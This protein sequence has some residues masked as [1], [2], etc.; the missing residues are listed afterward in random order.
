M[1]RHEIAVSTAGALPS[2]ADV[3]MAVR[4]IP[5]RGIAY[6]N[7]V[8]WDEKGD[9]VAAVTALHVVE[10]GRFHQV[11]EIARGELTTANIRSEPQ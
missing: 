7:A 3:I 6:S 10:D 9:N 2:R 8:Q 5:F 11:A 4:K 1:A